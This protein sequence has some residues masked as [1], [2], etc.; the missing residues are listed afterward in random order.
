MVTPW[1]LADVQIGRLVSKLDG[2]AA[3]SPRGRFRG[4]DQSY[5]TRRRAKSHQA[6]S[7]GTPRG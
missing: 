4:A 1:A 2:G 7:E 3:D 5:W 6:S